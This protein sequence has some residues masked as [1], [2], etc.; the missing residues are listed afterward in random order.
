MGEQEKP[1]KVQ[2]ANGLALFNAWL[3][4]MGMLLAFGKFREVCERW[5][6]L[7]PAPA[8]APK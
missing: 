1:V 4:C 5:L 3:L 7:H 6:E 8:S 2:I